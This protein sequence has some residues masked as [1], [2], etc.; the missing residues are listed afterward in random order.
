MILQRT[1]YLSAGIF[2]NLLKDG[3]ALFCVTLEHAYDRGD[4][5][6]APKLPSGEYTCVR[7]KH[8]LLLLGE[9]ETF[10]IT[11]VPGHTGILFHIGNYNNDSNGCVLLGT[12]S[13]GSYIEHSRLAFIQFMNMMDGVEEFKLMVKPSS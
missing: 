8:N 3:G 12:E 4:G 7:G 10:E 9:I 1:N 5:T 2:G 11:N 13:A 6:Y